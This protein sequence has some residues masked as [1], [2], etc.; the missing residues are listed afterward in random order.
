MLYGSDCVS[1]L[2]N[3]K[4]MFDYYGNIYVGT[5]WLLYMRGTNE[6][7][8]SEKYMESEIPSFDEYDIKHQQYTLRNTHAPTPQSHVLLNKT[9]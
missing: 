2:S 6:E 3:G 5:Q 9:H 4:G 8:E 1:M 7:R